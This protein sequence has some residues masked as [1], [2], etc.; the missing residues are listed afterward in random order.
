[1]T[2]QIHPVHPGVA[3]T[4]RTPKKANEL[5]EAVRSGRMDAAAF[6][7]EIS[8][9]ESKA[10]LDRLIDISNLGL[11]RSSW[12][13]PGSTAPVTRSEY[14]RLLTFHSALIRSRS[15]IWLQRFRRMV[16]REW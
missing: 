12:S 10:R 9:Q 2:T 1:M 15:W 5:D 3:A 8:A 14:E 11:A 13:E 4:E 16:G 6:V 7:A